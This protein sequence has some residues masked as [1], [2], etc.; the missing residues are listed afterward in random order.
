MRALI[1]V[2]PKYRPVSGEIQ[3]YRIQACIPNLEARKMVRTSKGF[4][5]TDERVPAFRKPYLIAE[6]GD[7][8]TSDVS[9]ADMARFQKKLLWEGFTDY[10]LLEKEVKAPS[11]A[12]K[13][14]IEKVL[15]GLS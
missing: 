11:A 9:E 6:S 12:T 3:G 4:R 2:Q 14:L 5:A 7:M 8:P 15:G 13:A 1:R 10:Q